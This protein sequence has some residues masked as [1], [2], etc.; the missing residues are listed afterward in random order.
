[1]KTIFHHSTLLEAVKHMDRIEGILG[2]LWLGEEW[3]ERKQKLNALITEC[4][5]TGKMVIHII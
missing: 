3:A 5:Q 1:M 4:N 2:P